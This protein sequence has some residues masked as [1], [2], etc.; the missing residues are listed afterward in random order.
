MKK[1]LLVVFPIILLSWCG[2]TK[3]VWD[4]NKTTVTWNNDTVINNIT[5]YNP[6]TWNEESPS[7]ITEKKQTKEALDIIDG[8]LK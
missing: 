6:I 7:I 5:W 3:P 1:L 8:L 2:Q 4:S